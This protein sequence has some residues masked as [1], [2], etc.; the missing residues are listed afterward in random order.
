MAEGKGHE[1]GVK[2]LIGEQPSKIWLAELRKLAKARGSLATGY[3]R[4]NSY[5]VSRLGP[6]RT[7]DCRWCQ[8]EEETME[9]LL[10]E[11]LAWAELRHKTLGSPH[12]EAGQLIVGAVI[13]KRVQ[14]NQKCRKNR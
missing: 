5:N 1:A 13:R 12:L 9:H 6:S 4:V 8:V 7:V 11:C 10:C 3:R 14:V 2:L